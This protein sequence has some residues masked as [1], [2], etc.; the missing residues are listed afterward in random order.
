MTQDPTK[1]ENHSPPTSI[2]LIFVHPPRTA[3]STLSR[4]MHW[5]YNPLH[6]CDIDPRFYYW[7]LQR[8]NRWPK[9]RL[10]KI[11]LFNGHIPFGIHT[12]LPQ[13]AT[14]VTVLRDPINRTISEYNARRNRRM[15]PIADRD[16]KRLSLEEYVARVP[17]NN[18]QTKAIAGVD[19]PYNYHLYSI[20]PSHHFYSGPCTAETLAIAKDNLSRY[21]SLVGLTERFEETLALAKVLFGWRIPYY[22][23]TR[24]GPRRQEGDVSPRQRTLIAE[25]N[26]FDMDLYA[27]GVSLFDRAIQENAALVS[28]ELN[29]V[30]RAKHPS[31]TISVCHRCSSV[32]RR[33][34][35][36][37][38]CAT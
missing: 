12:L 11:K 28:L 1:V 20:R 32:I 14:Y 10:S 29:T 25:Y 7:S 2:T 31:L 38:L 6:I 19:V 35:I 26:R 13:P 34:F 21:F 3:G 37:A 36:R 27:F 4:I 16:A 9:Q 23:S 18:P 15:H 30:R 33:H 17:Y 5:E 8:L 22:T 24:E